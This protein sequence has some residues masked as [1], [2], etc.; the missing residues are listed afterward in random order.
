MNEHGPWIAV[1]NHG[2]IIAR[3][4]RPRCTW[5][6]GLEPGQDAQVCLVPGQGGCGYM[7]TVQWHED[8]SGIVTEL[9]VRPV[10]ADRNW[11]PAGHPQTH[12]SLTPGGEV[13]AAAFPKGQTL[14]DIKR[15]NA[16]IEALPP[17]P[18]GRDETVE[19]ANAV[20]ADLG[21]AFDPDNPGTLRRL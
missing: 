13:V 12:Q 8:M 5:A 19:R 17:E 10:E 1:V 11:A 16:E 3:C 9:A 21:F 18:A 20:L 2:R 14:A 6:F 15:E 4:P 7:G